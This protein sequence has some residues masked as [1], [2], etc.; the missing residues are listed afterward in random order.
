MRETSVGTIVFHP[1]TGEFLVLHFKY[2]SHF[3]SFPKGHIE[4]GESP[5][6][7]ALRETEE[8]T[9][10]DVQ[11]IPGFKHEISYVFTKDSQTVSKN[12]TFFLA[13]SETKDASVSAENLGF[14][15]MEYEAAL[16]RL[17][18]D[19]TKEALRKAKEFLDEKE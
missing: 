19:N 15:W 18:F 4:D 1:P 13:K 12:V 16:E 9:G 6:E 11:L 2:K 7:A 17:S 3:W 5:K 14:E 10:L 8:E